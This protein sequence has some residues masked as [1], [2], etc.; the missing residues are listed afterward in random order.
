MK[1]KLALLSSAVLLALTGVSALA[2]DIA[3]E[4]MMYDWSGFYIGVNGGYGWGEKES[5]EI[6]E[7]DLITGLDFGT[8]DVGD[9]KLK[10]FFGGGQAGF[11]IQSGALVF[12]IEGDI[13]ASDI[14]GDFGPNVLPFQSAPT[15]SGSGDIDWFGT[16]RGRLGWAF[17]RGLLYVTGGI[18]FAD[19]DLEVDFIDSQ[20]QNA[21][22]H[23]DG[24]RTGFALGGGGEWALSDRWSA[25]L[26]Y[27]FL[28]FGEKALDAPVRNLADVPFSLRTNKIDTQIHTVRLGVNFHF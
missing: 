20:G 10:G 12:G 27:Q 26:E 21:R 22:L 6:T 9:L 28:D 25:K 1:T 24:T 14:D 3:P 13:Q 19:V 23:D 15:Y 7:T 11:N 17:D 16:V 4:P 5:V 2:A 8:R 18:A